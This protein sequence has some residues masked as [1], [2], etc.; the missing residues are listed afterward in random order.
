LLVFLTGDRG[1]YLVVD[2]LIVKLEPPTNRRTKCNGHVERHLTEA[3]V[4]LA[5]ALHLLETVK[6]LD[7]VELHPDGKHAKRFEIAN[8]L[9]RRGLELAEG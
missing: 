4:T 3:A 2:D 9:S 7:T 1:P 8:W 5:Y 6:Y